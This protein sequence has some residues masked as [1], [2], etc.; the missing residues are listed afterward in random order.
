[1]RDSAWRVLGPD[2]SS[3]ALPPT[4]GELE[5][6]ALALRGHL[7]SILPEVERAAGPRPSD[8]Q[9]YCALACIG[10]ARRKLGVTPHASLQSRVAHA[11]LLARCL[12]ALCDHYERLRNAP[13]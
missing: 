13:S 9:S 6:L 4:V 5:T 8:T 12:N 1:M 7:E 2:D 10:E 3:D 11:R